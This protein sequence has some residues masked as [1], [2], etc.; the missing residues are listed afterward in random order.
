MGRAWPALIA[1]A[2]GQFVVGVTSLSPVGMVAELG[3]EFAVAP[4]AVARLLTVFAVVYALS[5]PL[6]QAWLGHLPRRAVIGT[7]MATSGLACLALALSESWWQVQAARVAMA[8]AAGLIGPSAA[9]AAASLVPPER[10]AGA[11]AV[12]FGGITASSVLGLPTSSWLAQ[13]FGWREAWAAVGA[14]ALL[15]AVAVALTVPGGTRGA[16]GSL[17]ALA[18]VLSMRGPAL[19][20]A[21]TAT[22]FAGGFVTYSL[23][24]VW[25]VQAA[26]APLALVPAV[27]LAYGGVGVCANLLSGRV[28]RLLGVER[29]IAT[30]LALAPCGA[31]AMWAAP[32]VPWVAFPGFALLGG[33]W[34][35]I[36][37]PIQARLVRLCGDRAPLALAFNSSALY[38]GMAAGSALSGP[39]LAAAGPAWLPLGTA[40][41]MILALAVFLASRSGEALAPARPGA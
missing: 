27:L 4:G 17:A 41:G 30:G 35:M 1:L 29:T 24:A 18:S 38:V 28:V 5:A 22:L 14:A 32:A 39:I 21:A 8:G 37:A 23:Q 25:L 6:T 2:S 26:G 40:G 31:F 9:A 20:V 13:T 34:L 10:R 36:M 3:A 33:A 16:R 19:T 7:A 15:C 11:L 12:V